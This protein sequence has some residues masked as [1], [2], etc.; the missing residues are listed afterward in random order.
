MEVM[1]PRGVLRVDMLG[2]MSM[3]DL[4]GAEVKA[5]ELE[6]D[7]AKEVEKQGHSSFT[8]VD[9]GGN[10]KIREELWA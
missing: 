2:L 10:W 7:E 1:E 8:E 5:V 6:V 3:G 4:G 9:G